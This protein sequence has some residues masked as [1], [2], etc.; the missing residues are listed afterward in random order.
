MQTQL[1]EARAERKR[2][3]AAAKAD[4]VAAKSQTPVQLSKH[5][6]REIGTQQKLFFVHPT[7]PGSPFFLPHG[8]RIYGKLL[9]FLRQEYQERD[10]TEV[11]SPMVFKEELWKQSGHWD[12]YQEHMYSVQG[13]HHSPEKEGSPEDH[14]EMGLK[15]MNCPAHCLIY[16]HE[17]R[18]YRDLPLR[19]ADFG[20]L[21]RNELSHTLSGLTRVRSFRQDDAHIFCTEDQLHVEIR[22][23]LDM[24]KKVYSI[25]GFEDYRISLS[26]RPDHFMGSEEQWDRAERVLASEL[27]EQGWKWVEN[28]GDGAF[29]GPKI[30]ITIKDN[31]Q[32][33]HQCATIQLDFQLPERFQLQFA[34]AVAGEHARPVLIHRAILG[35]LERMMAILTEHLNGKWP[36]WLSPRQVAL[37]TVT[38]PA[39][40]YA[41]EVARC[42]TPARFSL[43][44]FRVSS[45]FLKNHCFCSQCVAH[46]ARRDSPYMLISAITP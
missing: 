34:T 14:R 13:A 38:D 7:S 2:A 6:H 43:D 15:P 8:A 40:D 45:S 33:E 44:V 31:L 11:L 22:D 46:F 1:K 36:L 12:H 42:V 35:S 10:Y 20:V 29:Y 19:L 25:L 5:D 30:D 9:E 32:R 27:D 37:C 17:R 3:K 28:K 23:C 21:H 16:A 41:L 39:K 18:S 24:V 26:T 4:A